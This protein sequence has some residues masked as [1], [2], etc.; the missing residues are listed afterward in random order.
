MKAPHQYTVP[1]SMP[2]DPP[3]LAVISEWPEWN[4]AADAIIK[5]AKERGAAEFEILDLPHGT[6]ATWRFTREQIPFRACVQYLIAP[7]D[8]GD[9]R[10]EGR[11]D[12]A[13]H[14]E[15]PHAD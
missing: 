7:A 9:P 5:R 10:W 2:D 3:P 15:K 11:V 1:V 6:H 4:R 13:W 12:A 14:V 8:G